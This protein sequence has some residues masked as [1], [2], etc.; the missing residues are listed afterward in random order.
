MLGVTRGSVW[1][2]GVLGKETGFKGENGGS[3]AEGPR[4]WAIE[5]FGP[6]I[7]VDWL[8]FDLGGSFGG[9][10]IVDKEEGG[11]LIETEKLERT[12]NLWF[13]ETYSFYF[14]ISLPLLVIKHWLQRFFLRSQTKSWTCL[15]VSSAS[16]EDFRFRFLAE[17]A[18]L[19]QVVEPAL[20]FLISP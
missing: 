18:N 5:G 14:K 7:G 15:Q 11:K 6:I 19:K 17:V 4:G 12:A 16:T 20:M 10:G 3:E 9:R 2:A 1:R 13:L 8:G